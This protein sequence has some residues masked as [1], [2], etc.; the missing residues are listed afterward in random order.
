MGRGY[1]V[2]H[3][4]VEPSLPFA[5]QSQGVAQ[6][7]QVDAVVESKALMPANSAFASSSVQPFPPQSVPAVLS[8]PWPTNRSTENPQTHRPKIKVQN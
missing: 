5:E 3:Q 4:V 1:C 7:D 2:E 6:M 8:T